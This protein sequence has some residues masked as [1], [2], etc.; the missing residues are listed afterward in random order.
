MTVPQLFA[1]CP[2]GSCADDFL[3]FVSSFIF[4]TT[5]KAAM[6]LLALSFFGR[7]NVFYF[8]NTSSVV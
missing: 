3:R 7:I 1:H 5:S 4:T 6:N 2:V 8:V